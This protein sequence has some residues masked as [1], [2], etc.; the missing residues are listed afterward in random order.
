MGL[1]AGCQPQQNQGRADVLNLGAADEDDEEEV[2]G[3]AALL[4]LPPVVQVQGEAEEVAE[5]AEDDDGRDEDA[6]GEGK[7]VDVHGV[8]GKL[9]AGGGG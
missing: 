1:V 2:G 6:V 8:Q 9:R 3:V 4:A 7:D 5:E